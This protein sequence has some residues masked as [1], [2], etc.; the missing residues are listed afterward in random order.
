[1]ALLFS[2]RPASVRNLVE[3][4]DA[5]LE[6]WYLGQE[7]GEAVAA[8]VNGD[9][10]AVDVAPFAMERFQRHSPAKESR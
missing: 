1:M 2:G 5:I 3:K 4:A 8:L 7:T 9:A 6:L 10:P